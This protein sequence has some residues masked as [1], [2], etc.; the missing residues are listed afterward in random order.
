MRAMQRNASASGSASASGPARKAARRGA[1][2]KGSAVASEGVRRAEAGA[3]RGADAAKPAAGG[4][5]AAVAEAPIPVPSSIADV[6][7]KNLLGYA[8]D[9]GEDHP[10]FH[11]EEYKSRRMQIVQMAL[12]HQL[13]A[14]P[15][16]RARAPLSARPAH[17][18]GR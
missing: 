10:G 15:P 2:C 6:N 7:G 11:D 4:L 17:R 5:A 9:L 16:P 1:G 18:R 3:A 12:D 13:C 8:S 14:R